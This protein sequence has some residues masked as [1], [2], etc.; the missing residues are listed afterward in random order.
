MLYKKYFFRNLCLSIL[1]GCLAMLSTPALAVNDAILQLIEIMHKKGSITDEEYEL[2]LSAAKADAEH[3]TFAKDE[4]KRVDKETPKIE[5]RDKI[6]ITSKDGDFQ[7]QFIGRIMA[8]YYIPGSDP[9]GISP[10]GDE[11]T[12][13]DT[14][15]EFRRMRLGMQGKLWQHWIWK[16]E[17]DFAAQS[18][19]ALKDGYVGYESTYDYKGAPSLWNIKV[20][21]H[22]I[23]FGLATM[24]SSKYLT[25]LERP[26]MADG[27]LQPSRQVGI[28]GFVHGGDMW[29]IQAGVFGGDEDPPT[30]PSTF[31]DLSVAARVNFNPFI[32]DKLHF[33]HLGGAVWYKDPNDTEVRVRQRPGVIRSSDNRFID[34]NLGTGKIEDIL[35]F[36]AEAVAIW[37]PF[38]L[39]G[40]YT[41]WNVEPINNTVFT[42]TPD[43]FNFE[44]YYIE[45]SYFLTKESM[46]FK[47]AEGLFSGVKPNGIVGKGGI[48][49]WQVAFRYDVMD[50][51]DFVANDGISAGREENI[52]VGLKWYPTSTLNFMADYVTVLDLDRPGCTTSACPFDNSE[53]DS[54]NLRALVYW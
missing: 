38:H 16:I 21:Q 32:K 11:L 4:I 10:A 24:S 15:A 41:N 14:E 8:D 51:N 29:N 40:E 48:G 26:L 13:L 53:P 25:L 45:G 33:L 22:H 6:A 31:E 7:W 1:L 49:A 36:N 12:K 42:N 43:D 35:A 18:D 52:R 27:E 44:G 3:V 17:Y 50:L 30:N 2:L 9:T 19:N 5:T 47:L 37:G 20:G 39:Q 46:N 28:S 34:A 23:P 54:F